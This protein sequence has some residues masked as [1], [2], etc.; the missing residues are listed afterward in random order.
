MCRNLPSVPVV[1]CSASQQSWQKGM[2]LNFKLPCAEQHLFSKPASLVIWSKT[3][4]FAVEWLTSHF[5]HSAAGISKTCQTRWT[6]AHLSLPLAFSRTICVCKMF[7][8]GSTHRHGCLQITGQ[9]P[10]ITIRCMEDKLT[11]SG[12]WYTLPFPLEVRMSESTLFFMRHLVFI[13]NVEEER[14]CCSV[15]LQE[16]CKMWL[17]G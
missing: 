3:P 13:T 7:L 4:D 10:N 1:E 14:S 16:C 17:S 6:G 9:D 8:V 2:S 5:V 11:I 15:M 12:T